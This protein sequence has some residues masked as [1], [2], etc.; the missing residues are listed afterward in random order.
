M[1]KIYL[2]SS[3][4]L[5]NKNYLNFWIDEAKDEILIFKDDN[6]I[7]NTVSSVCP[8]FGGS[9]VYDKKINQLRCKWHDW[10]FCTKTGKCITVSIKTELQ[11]Y[12]HIQENNKIYLMIK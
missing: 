3:A 1:K 11:K 5:N 6:N 12:D 10:R 4:D 8:H 2:C 7:I 9:I